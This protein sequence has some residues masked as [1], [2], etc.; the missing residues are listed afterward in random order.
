MKRDNVL[1]MLSTYNGEKYLREQLNSLYN[2]TGVDIHILVRD[3]GSKDK[4]LD[5]LNEYSQKYG[6]ITILP[7]VNVGAAK[8]FHLL[9]YYAYQ[10]MHKFDYYAFCDQDDVWQNQKLSY[11]CEALNNT[12]CKY[13]L[14]YGPATLVDKDLNLL[15]SSV[16]IINNL[17]ANIFSSRSL[18]CTQ[19][20]NWDLLE[21][22]VS[23]HNYVVNARN[24]D[25]IP[26]HDGW[27]SLMAYSLAADVIIGDH[28]LIF[29]RQHS[30]NVVGM[31]ES[32]VERCLKRIMRFRKGL[33]PKSSKCRLIIET[34]GN[35]IPPS[36]YKLLS[37]CA[38]YK[39][40]YKS[41]LKLAFYSKLYQYSLIDNIGLFFTIITGTF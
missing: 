16:K 30:N 12:K 31:N 25:Y 23:L 14:F 35:C 8:S 6:A 26:L 21:K 1:I 4:T 28:P 10:E 40:N 22:F 27:I 13:K 3:D 33:C 32:H 18:G 7:S 34:V 37:L 9:A 11:S 24:T 20:F 17:E 19:V 29:Y 39:T 2:Q 41:R 36:N 15:G 38:F 5:I